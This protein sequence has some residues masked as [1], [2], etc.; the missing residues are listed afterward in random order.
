MRDLRRGLRGIVLNGQPE[1]L[2]PGEANA[3]IDMLRKPVLPIALRG[4]VVKA[5]AGSAG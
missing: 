3:A 5:M 4:A 1:N 2:P